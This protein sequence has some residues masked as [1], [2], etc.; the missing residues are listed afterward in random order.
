MRLFCSFIGSLVCLF[1]CLFVH[2]QDNSE[3]YEQNE[4][5]FSGKF[6]FRL[7]SND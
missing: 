6:I 5:N 7:L 3:S 2:L 1:Y 4:M